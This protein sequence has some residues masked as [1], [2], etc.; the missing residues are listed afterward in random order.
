MATV[1]EV[2]TTEK[3]LSVVL[4]LWEKGLNV[5]DNYEEMFPVDG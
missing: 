1:F 2:Y 5:K 3:Q 4:F